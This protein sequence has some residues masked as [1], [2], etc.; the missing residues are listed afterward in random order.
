MDIDRRTLLRTGLG[1]LGGA[2]LTACSDASPTP[3]PAY[4][5]PTG[6]QVRAAEQARRPGTVRDFRLI[7][8][9]AQV[10]LGGT[11]VR[12]W[13]YDGRVPGSEIRVNAGQMVRARLTNQLP[14]DTTIHWHGLALRNDADGVP[15]VTQQPIKPGAEFVYEFTAPHPG[16]FWFHPHSGTQLDR[17]LYAPL[18]VE[19]PREPLDYD[20]EWVVV[21]DDWLDGVTGN[22]D[23]VLAELSRGMSGMMQPSS[24]ASSMPGMDHGSMNMT[25]SPSSGMGNHILMGAT[26]PLLG[27]DAGDVRYP[28]FLLNGRIPADP[29]TFRAKPGTR[30]RIRIINA[31]G[32]TAFRVALAGHRLTVTHTDGFAVQPADTDAL[33]IG[34]G[35]RYD[36][37]VTLKDGVFPLVALAEGK[38]ALT[39]GLIRTST[40][41][42]A[43]NP[44]LRPKELDSDVIDYAKLQPQ[45]A[46][47]LP[48]KQPDRTIRL[49][50]TGSMMDYSWAINGKKYDPRTITPIRS[51]ERVRLSFVNRTTMWHPMHLH[52]HTFAL[53]TGIRKDTAIV[54]PNDKLDVD[55]NAD[56]PGI[57]MIHCHNVYH[58]ESGMMALLGYQQT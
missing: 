18:I 39:R 51:G 24:S 36:V 28:H 27:G 3:S 8:A 34:M 50:L 57:W 37:L 11:T 46:V 44:T 52:G 9:Q 14:T 58:A 17:G 12:T 47:R 10:D 30:L 21:L 4:V 2:A 56:N 53:P 6:A 43:P 25:P 13:A 38:D 7:A 23:E 31:G 20:E 41:A 48:Q 55:F 45:D 32:D 5:T 15:G 1:L 22:P 16:T 33:L 40:Q 29:A 35:E 54:M 26:S 19:D 42:S 49:E